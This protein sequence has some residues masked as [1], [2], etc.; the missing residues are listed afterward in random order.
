VIICLEKSGREELQKMK[1]DSSFHGLMNIEFSNLVHIFLFLNK[2]I[3]V[4]I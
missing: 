4:I 1:G 2:V 3:R